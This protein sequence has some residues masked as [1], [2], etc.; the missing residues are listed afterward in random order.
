MIYKNTNW[1][2]LRTS[3]R[4]R[5]IREETR[6]N[7]RANIIMAVIV[8]ALFFAVIDSALNQIIGV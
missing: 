2:P 4:A 7:N 6:E 3:V 8:T 5:R 1:Q